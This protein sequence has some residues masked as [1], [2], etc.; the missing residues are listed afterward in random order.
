[1]RELG[2]NREAISWQASRKID[3]DDD[4][5]KLQALSSDVALKTRPSAEDLGRPPP[6]RQQDQEF[7]LSQPA[8]TRT[9][10]LKHRP[11]DKHTDIRTQ[12]SGG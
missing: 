10:C 7:Q 4:I 5:I 6:C 9:S 3:S 1:M 12:S 8:N 2:W 11:N